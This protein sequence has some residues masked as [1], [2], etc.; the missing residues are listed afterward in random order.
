MLINLDSL[1][2]PFEQTNVDDLESCQFFC[3]DIYQGLCTFFTYDRAGLEA[4]NCKLYTGEILDYAD[5]CQIVGGA[6][7]DDPVVCRDVA[8]N[9]CAVSLNTYTACNLAQG[10]IIKILQAFTEGFC[11]YKGFEI[12][13]LTSMTG[14]DKCFDACNKYSGCGYYVWKQKTNEC[15]LYA[16]QPDGDYFDCDLMRGPA[17]PEVAQVSLL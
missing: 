17:T 9:Q 15:K 10:N 13:V 14:V 16:E 1:P 2:P 11:T 12:D 8:N 5:T 7:E 3:A 4:R 6:K